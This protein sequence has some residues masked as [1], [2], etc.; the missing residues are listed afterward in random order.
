MFYVRYN[1][2][3]PEQKVPCRSRSLNYTAVKWCC[4]VKQYL[5]SIHFRRCDCVQRRSCR[6]ALIRIHAAHKTS[7]HFISALK[8]RII[9]PLTQVHFGGVNTVIHPTHLQRCHL[10]RFY[11]LHTTPCQL[12]ILCNY[13]LLHIHWKWCLITSTATYNHSRVHVRKRQ[14]C[15]FS[16]C[17][18]VE[19]SGQQ[20]SKFR[21]A[22]VF[23]LLPFV[24]NWF[25]FALWSSWSTRGFPMHC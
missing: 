22:C 8:H 17:H 5:P 7:E 3:L 13:F 16:L 24:F 18:L 4:K 19:T 15:S 23:P 21:C 14:N 11:A 10:F 6:I 1:K 9:H 25:L 12:F 20:H 2:K